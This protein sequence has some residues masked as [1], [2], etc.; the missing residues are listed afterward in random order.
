MAKHTS[1]Q[2]ALMATQFA[3]TRADCKRFSPSTLASKQASIG[4]MRVAAGVAHLRSEL[5]PV[6]VPPIDLVDGAE[7][8]QVDLFAKHHHRGFRK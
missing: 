5:R 2:G 1:F 8:P 4:R 6:P 7:A 3:G